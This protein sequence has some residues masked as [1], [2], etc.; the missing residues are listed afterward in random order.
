[1][2]HFN[3]KKQAIGT[4]TSFYYSVYTKIRTHFVFFLH[5]IPVRFNKQKPL[6]A[7]ESKTMKDS[8]SSSS[9]RMMPSC[10]CPISYL[11]FSCLN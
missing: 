4:M 3:F 6:F 5:I 9:K 2:S 1:M 8:G 7:Q 10:K 11:F